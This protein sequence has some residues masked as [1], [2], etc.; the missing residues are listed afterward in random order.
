M[1]YRHAF[2][3]GNAADIVK[4]VV[5]T[6]ALD[7]LLRKPAALSIIDTHAGIGRYD[8][9]TA[10]ALRTGEADRGIRKLLAAD[11]LPPPVDRYVA[12][13]LAADPANR[14]GDLRIYPGSPRLARAMMRPGDRLVLNE[15]HPED[16]AGLRAEFG[17]DDQ[18]AVH[19]R[20]GYEA[21]KA[22]LPPT[23]RRGMVLVDPPF[24][25]ADEASRIARG[26]AAGHRRWANGVFMLWYPIKRRGPVVNLHGDLAATGIRRQLVAEVMF[27]PADDPA[28]LNG[29]GMVIVNPPWQLDAGLAEVLPIVARILAGDQGA[30]V[31]RWLV[32]E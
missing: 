14:R 30:A 15:L 20:D 21:M 13:V 32:P 25:V 26:L 19:C 27:S 6:M 8:L 28:R 11:D 5:F 4:H 12:L 29:T 18:V 1:N 10:D 7:A 17:A 22:L 2:H 16:N 3:A 23:P 24:E 31:V 9:T